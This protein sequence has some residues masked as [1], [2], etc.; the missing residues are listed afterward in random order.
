MKYQWLES[1][2]YESYSNLV[3]AVEKII[4]NFGTEYTINFV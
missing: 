2:A 3:E 4:I 1:S